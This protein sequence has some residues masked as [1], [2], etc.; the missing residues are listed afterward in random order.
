MRLS[1]A[2]LS[3]ALVFLKLDSD[4][5]KKNCQTESGRTKK[6]NKIAYNKLCRGIPG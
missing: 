3:S 1:G 6:Q 2:W 4:R 5:L